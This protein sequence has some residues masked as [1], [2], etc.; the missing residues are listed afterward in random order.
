MALI[1]R[2]KTAT[3][4][5]VTE[6]V[7]E[8][9]GEIVEEKSP[10]EEKKVE[11]PKPETKAVAVKKE[12]GAV[13]TAQAAS[14]WFTNPGVQ[15]LV[16]EAQYGDFPSIIAAQGSFQ[17]A[18]DKLDVGNIIEFKAIQAKSKLVCSPNSNDDEAK[19]Y[20]AAAY[21]GE[22][23]LDGR[24][25]EECVQ[26]A[27]AAG[28]EKADVKEYVDLFA[29]VEANSSDKND[30]SGEFVILQLS[31]MSVIQWSKFSK[32]LRMQAA[33]GQLQVT[34]PP[35]IRATAT[36]ATNAQ[37]KQYSHYSFSLISES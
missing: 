35:T 16:D 15:E 13:A 37:K 36:V 25:I 31:P 4:P 11:Q 8:E 21:V 24:T 34:E 6:T 2:N 23:T 26:D 32:K 12:A 5:A 27:K 1:N 29:Y 18:Q 20:F 19:E 3:A 17:T 30:I 22:N 33:F 10:V 7:D 14:F 9:T 28:Y